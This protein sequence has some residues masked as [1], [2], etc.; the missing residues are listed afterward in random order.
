M[1]DKKKGVSPVIATVILIAIVVIIAVI[2][3]LWARG[4]LSE[5]SQKNDRAVSVSCE[6][7]TFESQIIKNAANC[8]GIGGIGSGVGSSALDV[9]NIGNVPIYGF[10]VLEWDEGLGSLV[11]EEVLEGTLTIGTSDSFCLGRT[12]ENED[13]FRVVPKLLAEDSDGRK[14]VYTCPEKDGITISFVGA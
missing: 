9:N 3:F 10:K 8:V 1:I 4:F 11:V 13:A 5:A 6:G 7:V 12:V 14:V 2:I